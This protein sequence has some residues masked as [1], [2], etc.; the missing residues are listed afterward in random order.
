[1]SEREK[2]LLTF[3]ADYNHPPEDQIWRMMLREHARI[4]AQID[5][6]KRQQDEILQ[7]LKPSAPANDFRHFNPFKRKA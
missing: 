6:I 5:E 7:L 4:G 3:S 1:M 2:Y